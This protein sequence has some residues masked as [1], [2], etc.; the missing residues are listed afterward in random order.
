[1]QILSGSAGGNPSSNL[2][3]DLCGVRRSVGRSV[4]VGTPAAA[5]RRRG[6][7]GWSGLVWCAVVWCGVPGQRSPTTTLYGCRVDQ[8]LMTACVANVTY[9]PLALFVHCSVHRF[10]PLAYGI[11]TLS[12]AT[13][14][15]FVRPSVCL[16]HAPRLNNGAFYGNGY[17]RSSRTL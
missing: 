17:Y 5:A 16:S 15:L 10:M 12:Y 11:R 13:I 8:L 9:R 1:M 7:A 3:V 14:S 4:P 2:L 6:S